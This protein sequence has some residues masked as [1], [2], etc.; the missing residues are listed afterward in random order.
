MIH[1][2]FSAGFS[3]VTASPDLGDLHPA[4]NMLPIANTNDTS[5]RN[6]VHL[7]AHANT[8]ASYVAASRKRDRDKVNQRNK[9][10]R[11]QEYLLGLEAKIYQLENLLGQQFAGHVIEGPLSSETVHPDPP[12]APLSPDMETEPAPQPACPTS[13]GS[14]VAVDHAK[15]FVT[16]ATTT[17]ASDAGDALTG[18]TRVDPLAAERYLIDRWAHVTPASAVVDRPHATMYRPA[19]ESSPSQLLVTTGRLQDLLRAP[20]WLRMPLSDMRTT[21]DLD[22]TF[23]L[24][25][26]ILELRREP[27]SVDACPAEPKPI[28]LLYG[29]SKNILANTIVTT[30]AITP[31]FPPEKYAS[32]WFIYKLCRVRLP[33]PL[34]YYL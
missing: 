14:P 20:E 28:D 4:C 15:T 25:S 1:C 31:L 19:V 10:R 17:G 13:I 21:S 3:S 5:P 6:T 22:A 11:E 24:A 26:I 33:P 23:P 34:S 18:G 2:A 8:S 30:V 32:S 7:H 29:G 12:D 27:S 16:S 9:R